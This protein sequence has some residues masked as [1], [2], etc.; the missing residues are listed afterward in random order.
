MTTSTSLVDR[1]QAMDDFEVVRFMNHFGNALLNNTEL[2][3]EEA[4][5]NVPEETRSLPAF[6]QIENITPEKEESYLS[7]DD[8]AKLS[9]HLL[10]AMSQDPSMAPMLESELNTFRD[11]KLMVEVILAVGFVIN[12]TLIVATTEVTVSNGKVTV[13][14]RGAPVEMLKEVVNLAGILTGK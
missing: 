7:T 5:A 10:L 12:L 1:I 13:K 14:K 2:S 3:Y 9:R 11:D 4:L 8:S 6:A